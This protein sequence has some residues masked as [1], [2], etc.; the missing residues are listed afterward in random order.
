MSNGLILVVD[1]DA[2]VRNSTVRLLN[3]HA[4][5]AKCFESGDVLLAEDDLVGA[6]CI[7]LDI[8]MPGRDGIEV[9]K[10]LRQRGG[11]VPVIMITGHGDVPLAVE[12]MREGAADFLEK[13]YSA[14]ALFSALER[15]MQRGTLDSRSYPAEQ[16]VWKAIQNLTY[17]QRQVLSGILRGAPNKVIAFELGLSPRTVEAYRA[18]LFTRLGVRTTTEAVKTALAL[19]FLPVVSV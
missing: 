14:D 15:V 4:F 1:D 6:L 11:D 19:G 7:L 9:L 3:R 2:S 8:R 12:A 18:Q 16:D 17:R 13:P 10:V 5:A